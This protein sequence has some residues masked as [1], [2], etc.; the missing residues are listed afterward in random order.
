V[1]GEKKKK[2]SGGREPIP[3]LRKKQPT[4][5]RKKKGG[6]TLEGKEKKA[7]FPFRKKK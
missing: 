7:L 5:D 2:E 4:L 3:I 1:G 6:D